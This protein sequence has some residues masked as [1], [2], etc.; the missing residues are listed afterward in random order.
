VRDT[1]NVNATGIVTAT[2]NATVTP[3]FC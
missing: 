2:V 3:A 1:V